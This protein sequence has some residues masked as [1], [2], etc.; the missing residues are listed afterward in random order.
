M[1]KVLELISLKSILSGKKMVIARAQHLFGYEFFINTN[2]AAKKFVVHVQVIHFFYA[3]CFVFIAYEYVC[4]FVHLFCA[5]AIACVCTA[6]VTV[7]VFS[8][9][10]PQASAPGEVNFC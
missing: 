4:E 5:Y 6:F 3:G 2:F 1:E 7:V 8:I 9:V 10:K